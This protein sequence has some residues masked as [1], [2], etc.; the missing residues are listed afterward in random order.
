MTRLFYSRCHHA[1]VLGACT[2]L[3]TRA[4]LAFLS[5]IFAEQVGLFIV[6]DQQL[7][8]AKLTK[9]GFGEKPAVTTF[10][11]TRCITIVSIFTHDLLQK[12]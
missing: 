3:T 6:N 2:S 4:D 12:N 5:Y 10:A 9:L 7:I 11:A 8:C 1:L